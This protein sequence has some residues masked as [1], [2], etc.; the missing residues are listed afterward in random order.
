MFEVFNTSIRTVKA[1]GPFQL[2]Q[3]DAPGRDAMSQMGT[4]VPA[5]AAAAAAANRFIDRHNKLNDNQPLRQSSTVL[6]ARQCSHMASQ[7]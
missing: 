7:Q 4:A 6:H 1:K 2:K 3:S 5:A